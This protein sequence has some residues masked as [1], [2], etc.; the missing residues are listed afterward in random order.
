MSYCLWSEPQTKST[1]DN[2]VDDD[3]DDDNKMWGSLEQ[4][5]ST[6][7]VYIVR[8]GCGGVLGGGIY[9]LRSD[10]TLHPKHHASANLRT[11]AEL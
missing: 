4:L 11:R 7:S 3:D 8:G 6:I 9:A 1:N 2:D 5:L 10:Y